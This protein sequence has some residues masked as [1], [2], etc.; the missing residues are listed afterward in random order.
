MNAQV[1]HN[2]LKHILNMFQTTKKSSDADKDQYQMIIYPTFINVVN[3]CWTDQIV[4][5]CKG[6]DLGN[7]TEKRQQNPNL[8]VSIS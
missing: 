8:S 4:I 5:Q 1:E 3:T 6:K 2:G 7:V